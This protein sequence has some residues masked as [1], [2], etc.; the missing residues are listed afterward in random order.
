MKLML[1]VLR[2]SQYTKNKTEH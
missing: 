2:K 1:F